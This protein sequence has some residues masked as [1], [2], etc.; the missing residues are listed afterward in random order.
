MSEFPALGYCKAR[1][2]L[3]Q[4]HCTQ[5]TMH[6]LFNIQNTLTV[7]SHCKEYYCPATSEQGSTQSCSISSYFIL[8]PLQ[9][10]ASGQGTVKLQQL[11]RFPT[12]MLYYILQYLIHCKDQSLVR[13]L[14]SQLTTIGSPLSCSLTS[15][16]T[17]STA[18]IRVRLEYCQASL[19]T[20]GSPLSCSLT[21]CSTSTTAKIRVWLGYCQAN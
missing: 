10:S 11:T 4:V 2:N 20:V 9:R 8:H 5:C 17:S 14:S 21:S 16:S 19:T 15:C 1:F 6:I 18:K 13:V 12:F 7:C 3:S